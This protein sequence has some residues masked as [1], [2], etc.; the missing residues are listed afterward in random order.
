MPKVTVAD[1]KTTESL[2]KMM[3]ALEFEYDM[4]KKTNKERRIANE[5]LR[6]RNELDKAYNV[7]LSGNL[8][9]IGPQT[10]GWEKLT[11]AQQKAILLDQQY[12][13]DAEKN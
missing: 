3:D 13:R 9:G 2:Q 7:K 4:L 10:Q 6:F 5:L 11:A 8:Q 1:I 12:Q